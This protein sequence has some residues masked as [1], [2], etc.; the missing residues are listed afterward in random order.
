MISDPASLER[1][2]LVMVLHP[3]V[4]RKSQEE[5]DRVVGNGRLPELSDWKNLPYISA[6]LKLLRWICLGL[7][8][9][10][11][12]DDMY[13]GYHIPAGANVIGNIW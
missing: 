9:R 4:V 6:L 8:K 7:P 12:E 1:V 3:H 5:T 2:F 13:R 10:V 11:M